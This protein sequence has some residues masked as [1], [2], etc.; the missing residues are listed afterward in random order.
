MS[1]INKNLI[2]NPD[3]NKFVELFIKRDYSTI[4]QNDNKLS[5]DILKNYQILEHDNDDI[6]NKK[7][8]KIKEEE[9]R[10]LKN[11][12]IN[13]YEIEELRNIIINNENNNKGKKDQ[14][15]K[16]YYEAIISKI[17]LDN[18]LENIKDEIKERE[19]EKEK[20][21]EKIKE[22][23]REKEEEKEID[24]KL[25]NNN[26]YN[27]NESNEIDF[28]DIVNNDKKLKRSSRKIEKNESIRS[29]VK[30]NDYL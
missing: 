8:E 17:G 4:L 10:Y 24:E 15:Y 29:K 18:I 23:E 12:D 27:F 9:K 13:S 14:I 16:K 25:Q 6:I 11:K 19:I 26:N 28:Y 2:K 20:E 21:M 1:N 7:N 3:K 5:K 22:I 30:D